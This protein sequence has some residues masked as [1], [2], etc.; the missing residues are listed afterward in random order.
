M[1]IPEQ[2]IYKAYNPVKKYKEGTIMN[3]IF[4]V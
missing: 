2:I 1:V 4:V 3:G